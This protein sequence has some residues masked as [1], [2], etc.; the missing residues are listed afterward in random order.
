MASNLSKL[1]IV[2]NVLDKKIKNLEPSNRANMASILL[3]SPA[4]TSVAACMQVVYQDFIPRS[5][6]TRK[7]EQYW[8]DRGWTHNESY[9]KAKENKQ[10]GCRSVFSREF[11]LEKIN[12][13]T[14]IHYSESE[15]DIERNSRRPI[16]KEYWIKKGH[17]ESEAIDLALAAK[18]NNNK[19]GA[20]NSATSANRRVSSK[21][22]I[23]YYTARGHSTEEAQLLVAD[24]Q[25]YF[26]KE[27]CIQKYGEIEGLSV[28][29][30]R[31]DA[32]QETLNS[33]SPEE[34]A[35]INRLKVSKGITVSKNEK[36]ILEHIKSI[37]P[38]VT[39]QF[40]LFI[41]NQKSWIYDI[42]VNNKIIEYH[43]D[44]WHCNPLKYHPDY[45]N[46]RTK[47]KAS[48][49]WYIDTQKI[50]FAISQGY[51]VMVVWESDFKSNKERILEQ[52]MQ[53]L[54]Q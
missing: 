29:Q 39:H 9:V 28:W 25:R 26:S 16:R 24:S 10:R 23:E 45:I 5:K 14:G 8:L 13:V 46:P 12:P 42:Q 15:A 48:D 31:Q 30:T 40:T 36:I 19:K 17:T 2:N 35:R 53:F 18:S 41:D 43:G 27:I 37:Y 52:C 33:K 38:A 54:A 49:K 44:F 47:C 32:W 22:C 50:D 34:K 51:N 1:E 20:V 3:N 7:S 6:L 21:R 11:W 4:I